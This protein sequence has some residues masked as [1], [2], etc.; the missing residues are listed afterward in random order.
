MGCQQRQR[1]MEGR[2]GE[3]GSL[4]RGGAQREEGQVEVVGGGDAPWRLFGTEAQLNQSG[5]LGALHKP[6]T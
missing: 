1:G 4:G 2:P 3:R 5:V 6:L